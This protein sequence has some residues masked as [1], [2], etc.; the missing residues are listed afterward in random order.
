MPKFLLARTLIYERSNGF[1]LRPYRADIEEEARLLW[2]R[3]A[4]RGARNEIREVG[5]PRA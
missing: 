1:E 5:Q 3:A 4:T 2:I